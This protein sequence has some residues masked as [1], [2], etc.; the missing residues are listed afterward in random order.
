MIFRGAT[1]SL[2]IFRIHA[3]N[4]AYRLCKRPKA[5]RYESTI[6][7]NNKLDGIVNQ[8]SQLTLLETA[9]LVTILKVIV[10]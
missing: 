6:A 8:I 1:G 4:S 5:V 10:T 7:A 2:N 3:L 9:D